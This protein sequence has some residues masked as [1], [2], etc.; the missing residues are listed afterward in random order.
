MRADFPSLSEN[1]RRSHSVP[2]KMRLSD[3]HDT[4]GWEG[5]VLV[6]LGVVHVVAHAVVDHD[7]DDGQEGKQEEAQETHGKGHQNTGKETEIAQG[8]AEEPSLRL[9]IGRPGAGFAAA[10]S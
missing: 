10:H 4:G 9:R 2:K 1:L 5:D 3:Q 7:A 6:A 8:N